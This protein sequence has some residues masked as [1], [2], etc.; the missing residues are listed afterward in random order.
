MY[1]QF[2]FAYL[3]GIDCKL[4]AESVA[5]SVS[6]NRFSFYLYMYTGSQASNYRTVTRCAS[7]PW[8]AS[9]QIAKSISAEWHNF[10]H[11]F[12]SLTRVFDA[13]LLAAEAAVV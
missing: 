11:K 6:R 4:Y 10:L 9:K 2:L 1:F 13:G 12:L 7:I 5:L 3:I 8:L